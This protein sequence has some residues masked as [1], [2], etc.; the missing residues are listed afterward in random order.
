[1]EDRRRI[2]RIGH[3]GA[4]GHAPENTLAAIRAGLTLG[5]DFIELD[6]Q[7]TRDERLVVIH[8]RLLD[9]TTNGHGLVSDLTFDQ[10]QKLDAGNGES[11]PSLE[12]ALAAIDGHAGAMLEAK[13]FGTGLAIHAAVQ[14]SAFAGSI[15]YASFLHA[16]IL[17]IRR[18][19]PQT[20]TLALIECV[21]ISGAAFALEAQASIVGL[22][23]DFATPEFVYTLHRAGLKVWVYTVNDPTR[24][25]H[26]IALGADGIISDYPDR[27]PSTRDAPSE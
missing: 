2:L 14:A 4:A 11:I 25:A 20:Q 27:I 26:T 17:D 23:S 19:D 18:L 24:I 8:D 7:R 21:P 1:M 6:I 5:V 12:A 13:S 22:A 10:L 15:V 3:R 16:E 9:R